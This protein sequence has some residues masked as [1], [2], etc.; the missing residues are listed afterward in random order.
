MNLVLT[1]PTGSGQEALRRIGR[2]TTRGGRSGGGG[3]VA[4][5]ARLNPGPTRTMNFAAVRTANCMWVHTVVTA[6]RD[7]RH[8]HRWC[9]GRGVSPALVRR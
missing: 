8:A 1:A 2:P 9:Q 3:A 5:P 7:A 6:R 4:L